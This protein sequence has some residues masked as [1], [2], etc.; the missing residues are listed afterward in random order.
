MKKFAALSISLLVLFA[1]A[2]CAS[3]K[4]GAMAMADL[5]PTATTGP[6]GMVHFTD[7][8]DGST[9]VTVDITGL[10]P[11]SVHGFHV[12]QNPSCA[13]MGNAAGGH[14]NPT[15]APHAAPSAV[16]HHAGDFGNVAADDK[17][18]VH[19]HF[20]TN[21]VTA[22]AGPIS[23]LGHSVVLHANPDDLMTQP[24]G[25]AGA[26]IACGVIVEMAPSMHH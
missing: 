3:H 7:Q 15:S 8:S 14:F 4:T 16:S 2:A 21:S 1:L 24:T 25:N 10:A 18:E 5:Q 20:T 23:V 22:H 17:G 13:D 12:H 19:M 26:R 11:H 6:T 9:E